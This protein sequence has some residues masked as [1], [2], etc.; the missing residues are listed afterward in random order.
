MILV[1]VCTVVLLSVAGVV[2]LVPFWIWAILVV[3][4]VVS[5]EL[6]FAISAR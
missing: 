2:E 5:I 1:G 4:A 3:V 6:G